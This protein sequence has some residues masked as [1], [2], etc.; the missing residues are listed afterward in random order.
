ME[1]D[2]PKT[3]TIRIAFW[4]PTLERRA[5]NLSPRVFFFFPHRPRAGDS[6][7]TA[8]RAYQL[9]PSLTG[10]S[11]QPRPG[12]PSLFFLPGKLEVV[13]GNPPPCEGSLFFLRA[14]RGPGV[15]FA[16]NRPFFLP[17]PPGRGRSFL[18]YPLAIG[19]FASSFF[20]SALSKNPR[21]LLK[22]HSGGRPLRE[23]SALRP[24]PL[25]WFLFFSPFADTLFPGTPW[26]IKLASLSLG[27]KVPMLYFFAAVGRT[28]CSFRPPP[29]ERF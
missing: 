22:G 11:H 20:L 5:R 29:P 21:S 2:L 6:Q 26:D 10:A 14:T 27:Q 15:S 13:F 4:C 9:L 17:K 8:R 19:R 18:P 16:M 24:R 23:G 7:D 12:K 1:I 25:F 3:R 28:L